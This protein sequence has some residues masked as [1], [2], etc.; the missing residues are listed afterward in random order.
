MRDLAAL[1]SLKSRILGIDVVLLVP[2]LFN[3]L[4][5]YFPEPRKDFRASAFT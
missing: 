4:S 5:T 2:T 3:V 1:F